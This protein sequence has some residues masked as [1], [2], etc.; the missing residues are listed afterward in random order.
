[1]GFEAAKIDLHRRIATADEEAL[2]RLAGELIDR[3]GP[4]PQPVEALMGVQRLKLKVLRVGG[5]RLAVRA[6]RVVLAPVALTSAALK[7]LRELEP[8]AVY[9]SA[10]HTVSVPAPSAPHERLEV[11]E[12]V[13]DAL[14]EAVAEAA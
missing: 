10:E 11:A 8:R 14:L 9:S 3:F 4:L 7:A 2:T 12:R 6:G 13:I 1:M 5:S